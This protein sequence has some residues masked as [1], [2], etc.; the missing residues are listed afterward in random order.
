M[1]PRLWYLR[2]ITAA[3]VSLAGTTCLCP[4]AD[5]D[6]GAGGTA[7]GGSRPSAV[8]DLARKTGPI[9]P[10]IYGQFIEHL[11][12][13]IHGGIWA[14][15]LQDR[16]FYNLV[17]CRLSPWK[18]LGG[19]VGWSLTMDVD[20]PYVGARSVKISATDRASRGPMGIIQGALGVV[21]GRQYVGRVVLAGKGD[22]E[23]A[24]AWGSGPKDRSS[25]VLHCRQE[26]FKPMDFRLRAGGASDDASLSIALRGAGVVWIGTASLM[27]ADNVRGMRADTLGLLKELG[28][29]VYRW[30]GGNFVSGYDWRDGTGPRDRRPPRKNPAWQGIEDNDFGIDEFIAFCR[31]VDAE[32]LV[33]VNSGTGSPELAAALVEYCNGSPGTTWGSRRAA[34]G[35]REPY[36]I[37]WWG[38]GN[39]MYG[40]WQL[41]HVELGRYVVR[42]N[43][44]ARAMRAVDGRIKLV[45][46]GASGKWSEKMLTD[47]HDAMDLLSE[48]FYCHERKDLRV[49]IAQIA[50][51]VRRKA[52]AHRAY[53]RNIPALKNRLIPI[54]LDEWNYWYGTHYY[55][56]LGVRYFLKDALGVARGLHEMVRNR[57]VIAMANYA[58]TVNVI[59]CIKTTKTA[60]GF[61]TTGLP[62]MLYRRHF[63]TTALAVSGQT[64]P[65]DVAAALTD[66]GGKL[67][68]GIVNPTGRRQTL[69]LD[70][71]GG[72]LAARARRFVIAGKGPMAYNV[73]GKPPAVKITEADVDD[74]DPAAITIGPL[75]DTLYVVDI[76]ARR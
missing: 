51:N 40:G 68:V 32:P 5:G 27:P 57:D 46:V 72:R 45:A 74:F 59:G 47:C 44:F 75:S 61:A 18:R 24:L 38:I 13:C 65:L 42:H 54:A 41:G 29:T 73:P 55:G 31:E 34:N 17:A 50:E 15:M 21:A 26:Q 3:V 9:S 67:T 11:G 25:V 2:A 22:V 6:K 48:H 49:H 43:E 37:R 66:D 14:E 70:V 39:E 69:K 10:Y 7:G 36:N 4:A 60:A 30:P 64:G 33:V 1:R 35:H 19:E 28:A 58:Q 12:R 8:V 52:A 53:L 16:K 23:V 62:L 63:G 20:K 76:V 56:Q 71:R